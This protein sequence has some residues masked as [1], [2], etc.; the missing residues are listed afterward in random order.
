VGDLNGDERPDVVVPSL[1][2][3]S[4]LTNIAAGFHYAT[5]TAVASSRILPTLDSRSLSR[6]R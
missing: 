1:E 5:S 2:T 4:V 3:V 6:R